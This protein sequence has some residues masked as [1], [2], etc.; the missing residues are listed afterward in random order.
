MAIGPTTRLSPA[1]TS[2]MSTVRTVVPSLASTSAAWA[3]AAARPRLST[4]T[5]TSTPSRS[6]IPVQIDTSALRSARQWAGPCSV[7]PARKVFQVSQFAVWTG[8]TEPSSDTLVMWYACWFQIGRAA[9]QLWS[10]SPT[11]TMPLQPVIA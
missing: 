5:Q 3:G 11:T 6:Q 10:T 1:G 4:S 7:P 8:G 2:G 9:A